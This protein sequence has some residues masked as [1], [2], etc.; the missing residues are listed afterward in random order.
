MSR[1]L[2]IDGQDYDLTALSDEARKTV[3]LIRFADERIKELTNMQALLS[4][5]K[6]SY[7]DGLEREIIKSRSGVDFSSL[8]SD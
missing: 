4:R 8:L 7:V 1:K 3:A 5:A 2:R 6:R